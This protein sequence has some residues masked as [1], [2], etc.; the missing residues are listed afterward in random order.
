MLDS[1]VVVADP[2]PALRGLVDRYVGYRQSGVPLGVHRGLPS[3]SIT[4]VISLAEP[5]KLVGGPGADRGTRAV[6][7]AVGGL[8]LGPELVEQDAFQEGIHVRVSPFGARRLL[9]VSAAELSGTVCDVAELPVWWARDLVDRLCEAPD[10]AGRFAV[11]DELLGR[12]AQTPVTLVDEVQWAWRQLV[13]HGG[14]PRVGELAAQVG[15]SRRHFS[16]RFIRTVGVT[17]KQAARLVRF[18]RSNSLLRTGTV[19]SLSTLAAECGYYDQAHLANEWAQ[20][21]GCS[22]ST[23]IAEELPFLQDAGTGPAPDSPS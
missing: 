12:G 9:G 21:A 23:W 18:E 15:W 6:R 2:E 4:V 13:V 7:G 10:W 11:L 14:T 22:P 5:I 20:L 1:G 8:H 16:E 17:P 3:R 19:T